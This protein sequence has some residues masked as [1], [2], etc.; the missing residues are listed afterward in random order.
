MYLGNGGSYTRLSKE[1]TTV[2]IS[3]LTMTGNSAR[4]FTRIVMSDWMGVIRS[5]MIAWERNVNK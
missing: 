3:Y 1:L 2:F 4:L 5:S